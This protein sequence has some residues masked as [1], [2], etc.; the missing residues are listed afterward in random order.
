MVS[1]R[2]RESE[3]TGLPQAARDSHEIWMSLHDRESTRAAQT[4]RIRGCLKK[5]SKG[6]LTPHRECSPSFRRKPESIF[7]PFAFR[8][9]SRASVG[10][11]TPPL[12][13]PHPQMD[14]GFRRNDGGGK[15][16]GEEMRVYRM[17][18]GRTRW[19]C[20][21]NPPWLS[22]VRTGTEACPYGE[23][24]DVGIPALLKGVFDSPPRGAFPTTPVSKASAG[25]IFCP[26]DSR[27]L[28]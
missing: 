11:E 9:G 17:A 22:F 21:D 6:L 5:S 7:T 24:F 25:G 28:L 15:P 1:R 13:H 19:F 16:L 14:S 23:Q 18:L 20:R 27:R 10:N 26:R 3:W 2:E 4:R 12:I 8:Q